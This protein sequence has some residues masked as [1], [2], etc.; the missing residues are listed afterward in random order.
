MP[1]NKKESF[2]FTLMMCSLMVFVM[3][4]YNIARIHGTSENL[5]LNTLKGFPLAFVIAFI[6]DW[7][8]VGP[9]AKK[10]AFKFINRD[11]SMIKKAVTISTFMVIGMVIIMSLF[12]AFMGVGFTKA[13][14]AA[15]LINIPM[16]FI[17]AYP[18]QI[19]FVGPIVRFSFGKIYP[20]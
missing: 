5:L 3:T 17:M 1:K 18:L 12:G 13:I 20:A 8:I 7:I 19:I 9:L 10:T 11:D 6:S 4:L 14:F 16:N 15:W 2:I